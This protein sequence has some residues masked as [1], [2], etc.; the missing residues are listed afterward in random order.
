[1][2]AIP[3]IIQPEDLISILSLPHVVILDARAGQDSHKSYLGRHIKNARYINLDTD[4][5]GA[6]SNAALGG[7][8]P[9]PSLFDFAK[10]ISELGI[11]E[12]S[13]VIIYDDKGGANAAARCWWLLKAFGIS[14]VQ[15]V[16]G[17][18][19]ALQDFEM[20]TGEEHIHQSTIK[21]P[22]HGVFQP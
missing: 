7:R 19:R 8:H 9:L 17:G 22:N 3:S 11:R 14:A 13:R 18:F 4:L 1:M 21:I 6:V 5:A 20:G 15:V 2:S 16:N 12:D 10:T